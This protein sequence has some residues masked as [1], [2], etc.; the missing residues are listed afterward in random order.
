[1]KKILPFL[2]LLLIVSGTMAQGMTLR[3]T[4]RTDTGSYVRLDSVKVENI[5]RSWTETL[6]YPDTVL[7]LTSTGI[8]GASANNASIKVFPNPCDGK[9]NLSL[10]LADNDDVALR[11][12][13]L[14][15]REVASFSKSLEAGNYMFDLCLSAPQVYIAVVS[16]SKGRSTVK[17]V[18]RG[19]GSMNSISAKNVRKIHGK[20]LSQNEFL[21]GDEF[22]YLG[23]AVSDGQVVVSRLIQQSQ[24][25]SEDFTM[26]FGNMTFPT[27]RTDTITN[28]LDVSAVCG[29]SVLNSGGYPVTDCGVCYGTNPNPT[30]ADSISAVANAG[31]GVFICNVTNLTP[32]TTYHVRAYATTLAGTAY[33]AERFF[34]TIDVPSVITDMTTNI[35][36]RTATCAGEVLTDGGSPITER[37]ICYDTT[38]NPTTANRVSVASATGLGSYAC[39][40]VNLFSGTTYYI[41]AYATNAAGTSYGAEER[42]TTLSLASVTT[43]SIMNIT[44]TS[45]TFAGNV[46]SNGGGTVLSRGFCY[47]NTQNP[48][49]ADSLLVASSSGLGSYTCNVSGLAAGTTYYVRAYATTY[50]GTSYGVQK[51]F[52]TLS[53]PSVITYMVFNVGPHSATGGGSVISDGGSAITAR[54]VCYDTVPNPTILGNNIADTLNQAGGFVLN[55]PN[56]VSSATYYVRA[57]AVN[58][59]G[60]TYGSEV[61]FTTLQ[62]SVPAGALNGAFSVDSNR[63]VHFSQGNLQWSATGGDTVATVHNVAGGGTSAGTWRFALHQYD[64]VGGDTAGNVYANGV[65]CDNDSV[66]SS[67][68]GWIDLFSWGTSGYGNK[69]PY[70]VSTRDMDYGNGNADISGTDYDWG[71]YNAISN[72]GNQSGQWRTLTNDEWTYLLQ[73][74]ANAGNKYGVACVNGVNGLVILPDIWVLPNGLSFSSGCTAYTQNVYTAVQWQLMEANG[75]VFLPAA[76]YR[77]L[78]MWI[79]GNYGQYWTSTAWGY[80][81]GYEIDFGSNTLYHNPHNR[82]FANSV[83]LVRDAH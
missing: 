79:W 23:Y 62:S 51:A 77:H 4:G 13:D 48:T 12:F 53:L 47:S 44:D 68:T 7:T 38:P 57:Y 21:S 18:N 80:P 76:G 20:R 26:F 54:G 2:C 27:V 63:V 55:F 35:T 3:F 29:V 64:F 8:S 66:S 32:R 78:R 56:L 19:R 42:F 31:L 49:I 16:T 45:A 46:V 14:T 70:M 83:R 59:V 74:R 67:Y 43:D 25:T 1:M 6:V 28:I 50:A 40:L 9:T 58:S 11:V 10:L 15:G 71:V 22:R 5:T 81:C 82:E 33:G 69:F 75:A 60:L 17:M 30:T 73:T 52:T 61:N 41:R 65:K 36:G 37:G 24:R 72:G 34:T 39:N